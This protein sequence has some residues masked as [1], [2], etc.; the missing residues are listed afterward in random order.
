MKRGGRLRVMKF[1]AHLLLMSLLGI[2]SGC[3]TE[4][5]GGPNWDSSIALKA[6]QCGAVYAELSN[7][8]LTWW[9]HRQEQ[10]HLSDLEMQVAQL[11]VENTTLLKG[12]T[13][14]SHKFNKAVVDNHV[15]RSDVEALLLSSILS[16]SMVS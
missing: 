9:S 14:I 7:S 2:K 6:P 8:K 5:V 13:D 15:L 4:K 10:M 11:C 3:N 1:L 16:N 12:L